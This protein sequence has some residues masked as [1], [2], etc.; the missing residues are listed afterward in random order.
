MRAL[1]LAFLLIA[2]TST[3]ESTKE[4][5]AAATAQSPAPTPAPEPP[6]GP[7]PGPGQ[8]PARGPAPTQAPMTAAEAA[9]IAARSGSAGDSPA[10]ATTPDDS[11]CK[12]DADCSFTRVGP[13]EHACCPMLCAPRVVTKARAA[14]LH[15]RIATCNGG[16]RCPEP[17]CRPPSQRVN[18]GLVQAKWA[19]QV[20]AER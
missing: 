5:P 12:T 9:A 19:W 11:P 6:R 16:R 3:K 8:A 1:A 13:G 17:M 20:H 2:C 10:R 7:A 4:A 14:E 18:P 15:A